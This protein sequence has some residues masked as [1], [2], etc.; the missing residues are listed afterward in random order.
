MT[1]AITRSNNRE[2]A[3]SLIKLCII[4]L[5]ETI[6]KSPPRR[7]GRPAGARTSQRGRLLAA[8]R[9]LIIGPDQAELTLQA[10]AR[11]AGVT[12]ALA[13]YYFGSREGLLNALILERV[14]PHIDDLLSAAQIRA[15][16]PVAALT[17]LMQRTNSLLLAEP[18]LRRCLWLPAAS[19]LA[20]RNRLR[21]ALRHLLVRAQAA[22]ALRSDLAPDYLTDSLLGLVL[23]PFLDEPDSSE[24]G[25][26]RIA[27][28]ALQHVA[29]LQDGIVRA[30]R[31]RHDSGA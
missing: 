5:M 23:F 22:G 6:A 17:F 16:Q 7:P 26:E 21:A 10:A 11:L 1:L 14:E 27:A 20:L 3:V 25:S 30:Q 8:A 19:A 4:Q 28:L 18:L 12:P 31:P 9:T 15:G 13:H 2:D 29:L 24:G